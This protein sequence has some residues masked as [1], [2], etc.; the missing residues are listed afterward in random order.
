[1]DY[2]GRYVWLTVREYVQNKQIHIYMACAAFVVIYID[3]L[4]EKNE[5]IL[6]LFILFFKVQFRKLIYSIYRYT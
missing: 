5:N 4:K 1:M 3:F 2:V 6:N